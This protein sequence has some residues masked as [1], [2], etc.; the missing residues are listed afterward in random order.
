MSEKTVHY[1]YVV[2]AVENDL[3]VSPC[4]IGITG[5]LAGRLSSL[6]TGNPKKLE[7]IACLP[8]PERRVVE[9]IENALHEVFEQFRLIGEWFDINP[10]DAAIGACTVTREIFLAAG[11]S[12]RD[13]TIA[14][15]NLGITKQISRCFEFI[16]HCK[17]NGLALQSRF[18]LN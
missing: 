5:S 15:D 2:A 8:I 18:M 3:P 4:K 12:D 6:Q 1:L 7:I 13:V 10:V 11:G 16:E 17:T 9:M 14:L